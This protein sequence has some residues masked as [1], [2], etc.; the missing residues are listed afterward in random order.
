MPID[1]TAMPPYDVYNQACSS[2]M[3]LNRVADKWVVLILGRIDDEPVR[4]NQL[5]R[6][7]QGISKKVL[8]RA[9]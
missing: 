4:F 8:S 1:K 9:L 5:R 3:V 6:E 7:I 2:R